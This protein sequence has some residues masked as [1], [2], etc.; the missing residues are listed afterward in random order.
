MKQKPTTKQGKV[1]LCFMYFVARTR[2]YKGKQI[3]ESI[4]IRST[5]YLLHSVSHRTRKQTI[6]CKM[7]LMYRLQHRHQ[8]KRHHS[9]QSIPLSICIHKN[10]S[11]LQNRE[12]QQMTWRVYSTAEDTAGVVGRANPAASHPTKEHTSESATAARTCSTAASN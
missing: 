7:C 2:I 5:I 4:T 3:D 1:L 12:R 6:Y 11:S 8:A 9:T 10:Y